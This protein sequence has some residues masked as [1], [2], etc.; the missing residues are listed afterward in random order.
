LENCKKVIDAWVN[1]FLVEQLAKN[2]KNLM[3]GL[4]IGGAACM[5]KK[6]FG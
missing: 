6:Q 4:A 1:Y 5:S 3:W 2:K